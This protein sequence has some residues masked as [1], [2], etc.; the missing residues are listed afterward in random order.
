[1]MMLPNFGTAVTAAIGC[2]GLLLPG[3]VSRVLGIHPEGPLGTSEFR[4]TYG[5]FFHVPGDR[6][7]GCAVRA[8]NC[9]CWSSV[10]RGG[11][12]TAHLI[13]SGCQPLVA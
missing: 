6:M 1:M 2:L 12:G 3:T 9:R 8:F 10:V 5:G 7:P 11:L 4:A 13:R